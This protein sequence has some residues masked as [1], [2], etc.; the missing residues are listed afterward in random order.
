MAAIPWHSHSQMLTIKS[1]NFAVVSGAY[2]FVGSAKV[3]GTK[4]QLTSSILNQ[5]GCAW[6]ESLLDLG[7]PKTFS[8]YFSFQITNSYMDGGD[9]IAFVLQRTS[10]GQWASGFGL[11][12]EGITPSIAVEFDTYKNLNEP[13][14]NHIAIVEDGHA[15]DPHLSGTWVTAPYTMEDGNVR[16]VWIDY[17]GT[18]LEIRMS[19]TT[20]RPAAATLSKTVN[21]STKF[22]ANPVFVGLT[23]ATAGEW[24]THSILRLLFNNSY[25]P[26]GIDANGTTYTQAPSKV[27]VVSNPS[28]IPKNTASIVSDTLKYPDGSV[29]SNILVKFSTTGGGTFSPTSAT[30][31]AFGVSTVAFNATTLGTYTIYATA[32]GGAVGTTPIIVEA[33]PPS[34]IATAA[35]NITFNSFSANWNSVPSAVWYYIDVATDAAFSNIITGYNN[36][37]VGNVTTKSITGLNDFTTYYYRVRSEIAS[38]ASYNSNVITLSTL[39]KA[40][41]A[42]AATNITDISFTANWDFSSGANNYRIDVATD[43]NFTNILASYNN[44]STSF[45]NNFAV[46]GLA[47][48]THYFYRLRAENLPVE[49]SNSNIISFYTH[50]SSIVATPATNV[51]DISF[52][53]NW[54]LSALATNYRIDVA[55]DSFFTNIIVYYNN[56]QTAAVNNIL[57]IGLSENTHYYYRVRAENLHGTSSNS[58]V[59]PVRTIYSVPDAVIANPATNKTDVSFTANWDLN[60]KATN[61]RIDVATDNSFTN[62]LASYNDLT[63]GN[64]DNFLISGL[65]ENTEYFY[66]VR[67]ENP[68]GI[69]K[70][71]NIINVYTLLSAVVATPASN[72]TDNSFT[73]NWIKS[74]GAA[75]YRIDVASDIDFSNILV[76]YDNLKIGLDNN[77]SVNELLPDSFYYYYRIRAENA[78]GV[79]LNSNIIKV[80]VFEKDIRAT[81]YISPNGDNHNDVWFVAKYEAIKDYELIIFNNI[82]EKLYQSIGY[83]NSWGGTYKGKVLPNGTYYYIFKKDSSIF[84]GFITVVR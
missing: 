65:T 60:P 72:I 79:S 24:A 62:I 48:N 9:G 30:T 7:A 19:N 37:N 49:S 78:N 21:I 70:N 64:V 26:G 17:D 28:I 41:V 55:K 6:W 75:N 35:T 58:N 43:T 80:L 39:L 82:G 10:T 32:T 27:I 44:L 53:A 4:L 69:S 47:P 77:F 18:T 45:I 66:R 40:P 54:N 81:N 15:I 76:S 8:T 5:Y 56:I 36:L 22:G 16:H 59:I 61:Y 73:A 29:A 1:D 63:T 25:I 20:T 52:T 71:S 23:S 57:I 3:V 31:N 83:D 42:T 68:H 13:D 33:I 2:Q 34:P 51:K 38:I 12:Y 50:L 84:N 67:A 14:G 46:V 11:G 74:D